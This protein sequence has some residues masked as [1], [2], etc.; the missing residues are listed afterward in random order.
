MQIVVDAVLID[1]AG[2]NVEFTVI[3][4][5]GLVAVA[6]ETQVALEVNTA[7]YTSPLAAVVVEYVVFEAPEIVVPFFCHI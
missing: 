1:T 5:P 7:L 2:I 4:T 3:V 6:G